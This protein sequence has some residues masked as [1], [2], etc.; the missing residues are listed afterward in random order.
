MTSQTQARQQHLDSLLPQVPFNRRGFLLSSFSA[1]FTLAAG[2]VMSQTAI[3]TPTTGL[4]AGDVMVKSYDREIPAYM[5]APAKP[6]RYPVVLVCEEIFGVHEHIADLCRRLA[7]AGYFAIAPEIFIRAG[8]P[9]KYDNAGALIKEVVARVPDE[10]VM[11]DFDACVAFAST[12]KKANTGKLAITGFCYG[13]RVVWMY[14]AHNPKVKAGV[15][16]Y[17]QLVTS[18][19]NA[20]ENPVDVADR[21]KAPVLGLYAGDDPGIPVDTTVRMKAALA[22]FGNNGSDI[23][24]YAGV[25]HGFNADY[26]PSYRKAEAEDGW[27]RMLAWFRK[28]GVA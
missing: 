22:A 26:R 3:V 23:H 28:N 19:N 4:E 12:H 21:L 17:G 9:R 25:P 16:W 1:G 2:P 15:A 13:G 14:A 18:L 10:S 24:V 8:D 11:K 27:K 7:R 20:K 5:A 6:G